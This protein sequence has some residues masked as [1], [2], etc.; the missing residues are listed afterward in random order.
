MCGIAGYL[1]TQLN[2]IDPRTLTSMIGMIRHRGPDAIGVHTDDHVGLAHAR[3]SIIDLAGGAQPMTNEDGS[4]WITFNGEIFNYVEL[5]RDLRAQGHVFATSS[6]TEVILHLYEQYGEE[7]VSRLNGQWAFAIWDNRRRELFLSRDRIGIR[8]LFY[9]QVGGS[10]LFASEMKALFACPQVPREIDP[11]ALDDIFTTWSVVSGRTIFR[12]IQELP[13]GHSMKVQSG[14]V[15]VSSHWRLDYARFD[16]SPTVK[17]EEEYSEELYS[18]LL[19]ATRIRLRSDVPVGAYLSGGLDSTITTALIRQFSDTRLRTFSVAFDNAEYDESQ[20]QLEAAKYLGT[21]HSVIQ[22]SESDIGNAFPDVIWHTEQP[23]VRT[24]PA[25]LYLLSKLVR[26]SDFKVVLTGEGSDEMFGGYDIFKEHKIRRFCQRHPDSNLRPLLFRKLYPYMPNIQAQPVSQLRRFF[27]QGDT[28]PERLAS[29][30]ARWQLGGRNRLFFSEEVENAIGQRDIYAEIERQLPADLDHWDSFCQAQYL[31]ARYLLPGYILSS[32]GDRVAMA[33]AVEGRHPFLDY[34][35]ME[36]ASR[37][38]SRLK[39][40]VLNE[41]YLLKSTFGRLLPPSIAKRPKQPYRAPEAQC[42]FSPGVREYVEH[43]LSPAEIQRNGL[44]RP[45]A[46]GQLTKKVRSRQAIGVKDN[47][48]LVAI[49]TTQMVADQFIHRF[50]TR[51]GAE[52]CR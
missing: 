43:L 4:L 26:N 31:E 7:C 24:A 44:F 25:P 11:V 42:L 52:E 16:G 5:A 38:P 34:R 3:L 9:T 40:K 50:T 49:A 33:H 14:R 27:Q 22:C 6:D 19:D 29:H 30:V 21:E 46:V 20:Y 28:G 51:V 1:N 47:M 48:A 35:V 13:P 32:Q 8:P 41:K 36:F 15:T 18:L 23:I 17:S 10:F 45:A 37:L 2:Q 12:N 39:M